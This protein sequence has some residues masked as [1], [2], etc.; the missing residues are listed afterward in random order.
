MLTS[1]D[2]R[3][4]AATPTD[5]EATSA[6]QASSGVRGMR[7]ALAGRDDPPIRWVGRSRG[8]PGG[9]ACLRPGRGAKLRLGAQ[10]AY[11]GLPWNRSRS[12]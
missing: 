12:G 4:G 9:Y 11:P 7:T 3:T 1:T 5:L 6:E 2:P 10:P 8:S